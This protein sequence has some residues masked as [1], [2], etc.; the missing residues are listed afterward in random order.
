[1]ATLADMCREHGQSV[2]IRGSAAHV[3]CSGGQRKSVVEAVPPL[4]DLDLVVRDEPVAAM[5]RVGAVL[6]GFRA[7][8]PASRFL[9]VDVFYEQLPV[10]AGSPLGNVEIE[11]MPEVGIGVDGELNRSQ[12]DVPVK[13]RV[14]GLAKWTLFRDLLYLLRLSQRHAGLDGAIEDVA[15]L[16][17]RELPRR[18]GAET[19]ALGGTRELARIDRA[20]VK[21]ALLRHPARKTRLAE[22]LSPDWLSKFA[23]QL[24]RLSRRLILSEERCEVMPGIAYLVG[25]RVVRF[26]EQEESTDDAEVELMAR[27]LDLDQATVRG[28]LTPSMEVSLPSP[29]DPECCGYR[30]FSKGI[31]ELAFRN[32]SDGGLLDLAL[33]EGLGSYLPVH[34]QAAAGFGALSLRTDPGYMAMLNNRVLRSVRIAGVRER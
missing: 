22:Y 5:R 29:D 33:M 17:K 27:K 20:L 15:G 18:I 9:H 25:G 14:R 16:L 24:S 28:R 34:A 3:L 26:A 21:H 13:A 12:V 31:S 1:M 8:V 32:G 4:G 6:E 30:D 2:S 23:R 10:R 11:G 7:A 19:R